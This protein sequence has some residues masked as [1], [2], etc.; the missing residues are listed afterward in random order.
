[1]ISPLFYL[2]AALM[3]AGGLMV[4]FMRNP[5]ASALSMVLSFV[6]LAGLFVGLNAYF[7][8]ILQVLV[9]AGAIMVLFIFIIMLMDL[10]KSDKDHWRGTSLAAGIAIPAILLIQLAG[11]LATVENSP[12]APEIGF[13]QA[14]KATDT[15]GELVYKEGTVIREKLEAGRLPDTHLIGKKLFTDY[16]FPLQVIAVLLLVATVGCVT[17]SKK[18][19]AARVAVKANVRTISDDETQK[20]A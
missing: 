14:L 4:V 15:E 17:L 6:G 20:D 11:V 7:V 19:A 1:M 2:F 5:V 10:Q 12:K 18:S 13:E 8:G 16:N 3:V 9:Y